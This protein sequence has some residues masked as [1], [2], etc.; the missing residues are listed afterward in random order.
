[1]S[2]NKTYNVMSGSYTTT[3]NNVVSAIRTVAGNIITPMSGSSVLYAPYVPL[4]TTWLTSPTKSL[5]SISLHCN[6]DKEK[7]YQF[8]IGKSYEFLFN[9][10]KTIKDLEPGDTITESLT[11]EE[12]KS[13]LERYVYKFEP[14][15]K[16][17]ITEITEECNNFYYKSEYSG[18]ANDDY[19]ITFICNEKQFIFNAT[20]IVDMLDQ[21]IIRELP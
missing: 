13:A 2:N 15:N 12:F 9:Y 11:E 14:Y 4:Q 16:L 17:F 18:N 5:P 19:R 6:N 8:A 10:V 20:E 1:M 7:V 3:M 21:Q